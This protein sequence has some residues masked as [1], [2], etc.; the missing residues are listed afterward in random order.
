ME[1]EKEVWQLLK[2]S[3]N[4]KEGNT[5]LVSV[6]SARGKGFTLIELL[7]VIAIV[8]ILAAIIFPVFAETRE[9]DGQ[10]R[11]INNLKQCAM[12]VSMYAQD[13]EGVVLYHGK[14]GGWVTYLFN[15]GYIKSKDIC[16]CPSH[17]PYY[18]K[19]GNLYNF[20]GINHMHYTLS[21]YG[22]MFDDH[23]Y[24]DLH[25]INKPAQMILL[26][27]SIQQVAGRGNKQ[28]YTFGFA[29]EWLEGRIH[30][31]HNGLANLAFADGHVAACD[32]TK[33]KDAVLAEKPANSTIQVA[34]EDGTV[35][36]IN[37][38]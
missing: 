3:K 34:K 18:Y 21:K 27:D 15:A 6:K 31:R 20:Y 10:T 37:P 23:Y 13:H 35:V 32:T 17:P 8:A 30:L 4:T 9:K 1:L 2:A 24:V 11:C 16:V 29:Q 12:A 26:A 28:I 7:S 5:M 19:P 33:I 38:Q 14:E 22:Y 25:K 36:N